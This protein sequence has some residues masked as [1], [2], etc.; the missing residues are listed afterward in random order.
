MY[1]HGG[2]F[3]LG[4]LPWHFKICALLARELNAEVIMV[5]TP[6]SPANGIDDVSDD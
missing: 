4:V 5:P 3:T 6:L 1:F 2:A